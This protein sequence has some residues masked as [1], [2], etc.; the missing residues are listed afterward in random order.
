MEVSRSSSFD[1]N[2]PF[3]LSY[4]DKALFDSFCQWPEELQICLVEKMQFS[5]DKFSQFFGAIYAFMKAKEIDRNNEN[6]KKEQK[7]NSFKG[8][9]KM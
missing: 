5:N 6:E 3:Q 2:M 7:R 8:F 4:A 1:S 9:F